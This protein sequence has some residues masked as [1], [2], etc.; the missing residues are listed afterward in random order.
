MK[1]T[2]REVAEKAG[3]A[4][5]TVSL[6]INN[7]GY[8]SREVKTKVLEAI[9]ELKYHPQRTARGLVTRQS[10]NFGFIVT[11]DHFSQAEPFYTKIFLG[12]EFSARSY[13]YYI[14][15]TT[16]DMNFT[17]QSIPRFLL[18]RNVDGVILAGTVPHRIVDYIKEKNYPQILIDY[19]FNDQNPSLVMIDNDM[20]IRLVIEHLRE[21]GHQRLAFIGG[22]MKH[23]GMLERKNAFIKYC[24]AFEMGVDEKCLIIEQEASNT[25]AGLAAT[26]QL[27]EQSRDFTAIVAAN[28]AMAV[29]ALRACRDRKIII[30]EQM[31]ITGFD[32][33]ESSITA[34]PTLTTV[35]VPKEEMG[36]IAVRHLVDIVKNHSEEGIKTIMPVKLVCRESTNNKTI[37]K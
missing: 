26:N 2:I 15:L 32:N 25:A 22:D 13:D 9:K 24:R 3:V 4:V 7:K 11:A 33:V 27:L 10:G 1:T 8:V 6:V 31:A 18:E 35:H 37:K 34:R 20:G 19:Y 12:C 28:D 5:S 23:P 30:P 17:S 36:A 29:G 16:I 21:M 14:L